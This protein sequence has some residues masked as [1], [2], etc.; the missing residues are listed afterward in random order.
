MT[1]TRKKK[2]LVLVDWY[3]PGYKAGGPIQSV[4]NMVARLKNDF[5]FAIIT[6]DTDDN[7][8][9]PYTSVKSD[10]WNMLADGTRVY[11][12]SKEGRKFSALKKVLLQEHADVIYLNSLFSVFFTMYPLIIRKFFLSSI[13]TVLATRGMLGKGALQIKAAKKKIF[14]ST[15]K[16]T[17]LYKNITWHASTPLEA[18]EITL[19]FG[20]HQKVLVATNLTS[21]KPSPSFNRSKEINKARFVFLSRIATKKNLLASIQTIIELPQQYG[22]EFDIYGPV[23]DEAYWETCKEEMAKALPHTV[24]NYKG[25]IANAEASKVLEQYHFSLLQTHHENFGHSI[26]ESMAAGCVVVI[27]DQTPW[28]NLASVKAGW[29][30]PG[31]DE[32]ALLNTLK[33]CC[34]MNR[35]TFNEWSKAAVAYAEKVINNPQLLEDNKKL[36]A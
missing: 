30:I 21:L 28:R 33:T 29:D 9:V 3:L 8:T 16:T 24:I 14:L 10:S 34:E 19:N 1:G 23:D 18:E 32:A 7:E 22:V 15:A 13:K 5:E 31:N 11:Y 2:I 17:G 26:V 35:E 6:S 4:A 25:A 36:F 20:K 12:F 27:S